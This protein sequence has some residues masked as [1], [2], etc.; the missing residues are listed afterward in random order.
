MS[1]GN[2]A[3]ARLE[4]LLNSHIRQGNVVPFRRPKSKAPPKPG[5]AG[6]QVRVSGTG[7]AAVVG[8]HNSVTINVR[9]V[10]KKVV[11]DVKP[12]E[13]HITDAEAARLH[14]LV[15][16]LHKRTATPH[17][18]IWTSLLRNV[19]APTYRLIALDAFPQAESYL[20]K[21]LARSTPADEDEER[22]RLRHIKYIKTNQRNLS[23]SDEE[24]GNF[25]LD[26]FGKDGLRQCSVDELV[27]VRNELVARWRHAF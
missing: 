20:L 5:A 15:H 3:E 7:N 22:S 17:Q 10:R 9:T 1:A 19:K 27:V 2:D 18:R 4:A 26:R 16:D 23:K 24:L 6:P 25:L 11:A 13:E 12:G 14:Q 8:S 21:W